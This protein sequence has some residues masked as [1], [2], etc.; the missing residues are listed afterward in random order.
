MPCQAAVDG[1]TVRTEMH[2]D[3]L[4]QKIERIIGAIEHGETPTRVYE[5]YVFGSYRRG[6]VECGDLDLILVVEPPTDE[7]REQFG[8]NPCDHNTW[9]RINA[10][11]RRSLIRRGEKVHL[12]ICHAVSLFVGEGASIKPSDVLLLWADGDRRWRKKLAEITPDPT[13]GRFPR[14]HFVDL[15]RTSSSLD[16]MKKVQWLLEHKRLTLIREPMG[17]REP[18]LSPAFEDLF[19]RLRTLERS[20]RKTLEVLPYALAWLER[21]GHQPEH[22]LWMRCTEICSRNGSH[23]IHIGRISLE[24]MMYWLFDSIRPTGE[25]CLIPH[26]RRNQPKELLVFQRGPRWTGDGDEYHNS[27][28]GREPKSGDALEDLRDTPF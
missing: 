3:K 17:D 19:R 20:G 27:R 13:A 21:E 2:R 18:R 15:N 1:P 26:I 8:V 23:R 5:L 28:S 16:A 6:A 22:L 25:V 10:A 14:N 7:L 12:L 11:V 24:R 4:T 9:G